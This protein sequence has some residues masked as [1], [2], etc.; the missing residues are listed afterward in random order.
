MVLAWTEA[1][2][3]GHALIDSHHREIFRRYKTFLEKCDREHSIEQLRDLFIYLQSYV[4][5]HFAAEEGLMK[6]HRYPELVEHQ[7]DHIHFRERLEQ[8]MAEFESKGPNIEILVHTN[9]TLVLWLADHIQKT[10]MRLAAFLR[11]ETPPE[12]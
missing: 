6:N 2:A 9:K 5:E 1:L 7:K 8:L 3:V 11:D 4:A 10:D 12:D